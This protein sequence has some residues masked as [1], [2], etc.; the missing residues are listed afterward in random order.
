MDY[1]NENGNMRQS[2]LSSRLKKIFIELHGY[3]YFHGPSEINKIDDRFIGRNHIINKLKG[4]LTNTETRSGAY[5]VTGYRGMG[6]SSFVSKAISEVDPS[7]RD[8]VKASRYFRISIVLLLFSFIEVNFGKLLSPVLL[9]GVPLFSASILLWY[10]LYTDKNR[11]DLNFSSS[12]EKKLRKGFSLFH[13]LCRSFILMT[14]CESGNTFRRVL[15]V[16][17]VILFIQTASAYISSYFKG[18]LIRLTIY[19]TF[20]ILFIS[21][22]AAY[23]FYTKNKHHWVKKNLPTRQRL[24]EFFNIL[25]E[26]IV[27]KVKNFF[28]YSKRI[29]IKLNLGYDDLREI[30]ILRL[31]SKNMEKEYNKKIK[32]K[33]FS[34][35]ISTIIRFSILYF[36]IGLI[37]YSPTAYDLNLAIKKHL[38]FHDYFPT[39][40]ED[41]HKLEE[42]K[43]INKEISSLRT[44]Y[45]QSTDSSPNLIKKTSTYFDLFVQDIY[46]KFSF[47]LGINL[48]ISEYTPFK[49]LKSNF[50]LLPKTLDYLFFIYCFFAYFV[51]KLFKYRKNSRSSSKSISKKIK[52]LNEMIDYHITDE[53][54]EKSGIKSGFSLNYIKKRTKIHYKADIREI[55]KNL[56]DI[57]DEFDRYSRFSI[58]PE[59]I[60]IF[61]ELDKIEPNMNLSVAQNEEEKSILIPQPETTYFST[62]GVRRRQHTIFKILSN[63]KHFLNTAKA[64]FIFIAG[65]ELYDAALADVSDR[66][67]FVGSIF[68]SVIYVNS[69]LTDNS[70]NQSSNLLSMTEKYVCQYLFPPHYNVKELSLKEYQKYLKHYFATENPS[71]KDKIVVDRK[72]NKII[73]TLLNFITY[74]TYRSNGAPKK[75]TTFFEYYLY[76]PK[77]GRMDYQNGIYSDYSLCIGINSRNLYLEFGYYDQYTFGMLSYLV[78]PIMLSVS[79]SIKDYGDKLL[80]S[81]SFLLD[82]LSGV[83]EK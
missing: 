13:R 42:F 59:F 61:D 48:R 63:L 14:K 41:F 15:Q 70:D 43:K 3:S 6:K 78:S 40:T 60:Y 62:E 21:I 79:K 81:T 44:K 71:E 53:S 51:I 29:Y 67:F 80:V 50:F 36:I 72:I 39:Q 47:F 45:M 5:L 38:N 65:R 20:T 82:H 37:Y 73:V 32:I 10:F 76:R 57:L 8:S 25:S 22:N 34:T 4:L 52:Q 33:R 2:D 46:C 54:S 19:S 77:G 23:G 18:Y 9:L 35:I 1:K 49:H 27:E 12:K 31:I 26:K 28:N 68:H 7:N 55:E 66:N 56:I 16:V 75:L 83:W 17:Y 64:K 74:L 24:R 69:F 30:D 11:N 58:K